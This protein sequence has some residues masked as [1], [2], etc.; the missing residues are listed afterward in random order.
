[1]GVIE[2]P[3]SAALDARLAALT[4]EIKNKINKWRPDAMAVEE[5]FFMKKSPS[6]LRV[7]Q[8]RGAVIAVAAGRGIEVFEYNPVSVKKTLTG[9][10]SASKTQMQAMIKTILRLLKPPSPDDAADAAA[11]ALC[12]YYTRGR[13]R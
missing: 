10:G 1:L 7:A 3:A 2:T 8:A 5:L 13:Y 6:V 11:I 12:H 4:S 9:Y